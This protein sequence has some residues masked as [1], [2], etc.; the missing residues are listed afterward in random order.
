MHE[1]H[2]CLHLCL[3]RRARP[4]AALCLRRAAAS[5][6]ASSPASSRALQHRRSHGDGEDSRHDRVAPPPSVG[7]EGGSS[8]AATVA[9]PAQSGRATVATNDASP[10]PAE[11][12]I[13]Q[14]RTHAPHRWFWGSMVVVILRTNGSELPICSYAPC[15]PQGVCCCAEQAVVPTLGTVGRSSRASSH[16]KGTCV[17][18]GKRVSTD[19]AIAQAGG[20]LLLPVCGGGSAGWARWRACTPL[21]RQIAGA[22]Q[23][24]LSAPAQTDVGWYRLFLARGRRCLIIPPPSRK[25]L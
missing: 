22:R 8:R 16:P 11:P 5:S 4:R 7:E 23:P 15:N 3:Q 2:V 18:C 12:Q 1:R 17:R 13:C 9:H 24:N 25:W 14:R 6:P 21:R 10:P 19:P 20:L